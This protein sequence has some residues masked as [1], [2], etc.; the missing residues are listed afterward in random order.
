MHVRATAGNEI[1]RRNSREKSD[2]T[3]I[4]NYSM[5][6][7]FLP[8]QCLHCEQPAAHSRNLSAKD[9]LSRYLCEVC[10]RMLDYQEAP[11]EASIRDQFYRVAS[12]LDISHCRAAYSFAV[13]S[14]VQSIV[15]AFKYSGMP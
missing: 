2:Q 11:N 8:E 3:A 14:P 7:L 12:N 5:F 6:S 9:T 1:Y 15:H 13:H 4:T 10:I